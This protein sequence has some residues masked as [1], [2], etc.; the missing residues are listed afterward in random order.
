MQLNDAIIG[1]IF[2]KE[3]PRGKVLMNHYTAVLPEFQN[4]GFYLALNQNGF[5]VAKL[6]YVNCFTI[7]SNPIT[8]E[9]S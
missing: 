4:H 9:K 1:D 7:T 8:Y 3:F 6:G 2:K 5:R